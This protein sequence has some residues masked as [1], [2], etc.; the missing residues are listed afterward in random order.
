MEE[1]AV[2][3]IPNRPKKKQQKID[4]RF[5][6]SAMGGFTLIM[7]LG[8]TEIPLGIEEKFLNSSPVLM[9]KVFA[10]F[11]FGFLT[12]IIGR[13]YTLITLHFI[14]VFSSGIR[15]FCI[16]SLL[17]VAKYSREIALCGALTIL[18]VYFGEIS[19]KK[20]RGMLIALVYS[21]YE[22]GFHS[23][24]WL[25][26]FCPIVTAMSIAHYGTMI[27]SMVMSVIFATTGRETLT[28][29]LLREKFDLLK[30]T[31][32]NLK[33]LNVNTDPELGDLMR[34]MKK[35][36]NGND[37]ILLLPKSREWTKGI[38]ILLSLILFNFCSGSYIIL[39]IS[40]DYYSLPTDPIIPIGKTILAFLCPLL[41]D[42][43][44][45]IKCLM[46]S[47]SLMLLNLSL[48]SI[49][50]LY[51][52][53]YFGPNAAIMLECSFLIACNTGMVPLQLVFQGELFPMKMKMVLAAT[54]TA[55]FFFLKCLSVD[56][57]YNLFSLTMSVI[58]C[59]VALITVKFYYVETRRR[60]LNEIQS[61]LNKI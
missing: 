15:E 28:Y 55:I 39:N 23:F 49:M 36:G 37:I 57:E 60:S 22:L 4:F 31:L 13:K 19:D 3:V 45:R 43:I 30:L 34:K 2:K 40:H 52:I 48:I 18:P 17:D 44:G 26:I 29:Y 41:V 54:T 56:I 38:L 11:I 6:S 32:E 1:I 58:S 42:G 9:T 20:Y 50:T 16:L 61:I 8:F 53:D 33:N 7:L 25:A 46:Y 35:S 47:F 5:L 27:S 51:K 12:E 10:S 21:F 59:V 14:L 24:Q